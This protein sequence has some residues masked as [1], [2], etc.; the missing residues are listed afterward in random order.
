V[1]MSRGNRFSVLNCEDS[2]SGSESAADDAEPLAISTL[3]C[4][5]NRQAGGRISIRVGEVDPV[6]GFSHEDLEATKK[7]VSILGKNPHL[8]K[9]PQLKSLRGELHPLIMEQLKNYSK[10]Q[11]ENDINSGR[12]TKRK[13]R[14]RKQSEYGDDAAA[15]MER[16][17]VNQTQLRAIRLQQLNALNTQ[18]EKDVLRVPDGVGILTNSE[19]VLLSLQNGKQSQLA[20]T[21]APVPVPSEEFPFPDLRTPLSCYICHKPYTKLHFF[22]AQLCPECSKFNFQKR[23]EKAN[24]TG[25]IMLVTGARQKIGYRSVLKLLRCGA[26]VIGTTRFPNDCAKKYERESD[27]DV[28]KS[29]LHIYGCDFRDLQSLEGLCSY[30]IENYS[31][32]DAIVNN[33]CQT[34]RRPPVYYEHLLKDERIRP[35]SEGSKMLLSKQWNFVDVMNKRVLEN[36]GSLLKNQEKPTSSVGVANSPEKHPSDS[37]ILDEKIKEVVATS[38]ELQNVH[39]EEE[40]NISEQLPR[41]SRAIPVTSYEMTQMQLVKGDELN[42]ENRDTELFPEGFTDVNG[43]QVDCR[44]QN[45][46]TMKLHEVST[47]E[48]AEVFAINAIAPAV[49][50]A[51][52]KP[53]MQRDKD[54]MKFIVNVSAMEGKFY[55]FKQ[56]THPHTN[57]AKAALNMMTRTSAQDYVKSKIYMTAVDTGWI[58]D[59]KPLERAVSHEKKHNFQTPIDE[60]DAASRVLDPIIAPLKASQDGEPNVEPPFGVFLKDYTMCEW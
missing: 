17:Y 3:D 21:S 20:Q 55:R 49:I 51:R 33:A 6:L 46:W 37:P 24:L 7:V 47:P 4:T 54:A 22:Y 14:S 40:L 60:V 31:R 8:F 58:N 48:L 27:F 50:N 53:L 26:F 9:L 59:E 5:K 28:W 16:E 2:D 32:L 10:P 15:R 30:I 44:K 13:R 36:S 29:R 11:G 35:A 34:I 23:D 19:S 43:Q 42:G 39:C 18:G 52:L 1:P 56:D 38:I 41:P 45:S 57:M 12:G 25:M